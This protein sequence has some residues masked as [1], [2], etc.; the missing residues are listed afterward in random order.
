MRC[1]V[2]VITIAAPRISQRTG[3]GK[4]R[5]PAASA[6]SAWRASSAY[7]TTPM[8]RDRVSAAGKRSR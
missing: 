7:I 6:S 8:A 5:A 2:V 1:A 3:A 4:A